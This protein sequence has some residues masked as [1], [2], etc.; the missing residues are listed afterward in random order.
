MAI[1]KVFV[2]STCYDL[3]YI[4]ENLKLFIE[5][6]GYDS[7]FSENGD[8]YYD[9]KI[10]TH[11][12][13]IN[14]V[15]SCQLLVL[16]IG[17]RS[18]GKF[19]DSDKSITNMEYR[20]AIEQKI[21]VFTLIEDAVYKEHYVYKENEKNIAVNAKEITYPNIDDIK[22]LEFIDEV[23]RRMSNNAFFTFN[24]YN[25]IEQYLKKQW[26]GMMYR[27]LTDQSESLK[28]G[29]L[30]KQL[31]VATD[32]IEVYT[33]QTAIAVVDSKTNNIVNMY[34]KLLQAEITQ[35]L[36]SW[37]IHLTPKL[38]LEHDSLDSLC[39]NQII[40]YSLEGVDDDDLDTLYAM[41]ITTGG[42]PPYEASPYT[43]NYMREDYIALRKE[44]NA[45]MIENKLS[46]EEI[47]D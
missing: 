2:S 10:H 7:V 47:G 41:H 3:K 17:G 4:R 36:K 19:R 20:E 25:D 14:E 32:K 30:L 13:C 31:Q 39:D 1:P 33:K 11:D 40:E 28:V 5:S 15:S 44:I 21:P 24:D 6:Q 35:E 8:I 22:I 43:V 16:I 46:L 18:G 26:A 37:N 34:D 38:I 29:D 27:F 9:P 23:K 42:G 45:I 12:A